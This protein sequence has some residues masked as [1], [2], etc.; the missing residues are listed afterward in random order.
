MVNQWITT[1]RCGRQ[2]GLPRAARALGN[3]Q[4]HKERELVASSTGNSQGKTRR[5]EATA[6]LL[7]LSGGMP[8]HRTRCSVLTCTPFGSGYL[9]R[10]LSPLLRAFYQPGNKQ[11]GTNSP[12]NASCVRF[13]G[14]IAASKASLY[15]RFGLGTWG[16]RVAH[17]NLSRR[18]PARG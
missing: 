2:G 3:Q 9:P 4:V 7:V 11:R 6:Q 16:W 5:E 18:C 15:P 12:S 10:V 8:I 14:S 1:R 17:A 13:E